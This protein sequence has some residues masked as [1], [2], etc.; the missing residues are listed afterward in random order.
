MTKKK[1]F[2]IFKRIMLCIL[3]CLFLFISLF[4]AIHAPKLTK[5]QQ[6]AEDFQNRIRIIMSS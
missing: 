1:L 2:T 4:N 3:I 5:E 6:E